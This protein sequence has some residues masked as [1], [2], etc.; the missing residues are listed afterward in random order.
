MIYS[1]KDA[2]KTSFAGMIGCMI[3]LSQKY[4]I[5]CS[6]SQTVNAAEKL[7]AAA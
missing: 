4:E 1:L 7:M 3:G 2:M 5:H 6:V